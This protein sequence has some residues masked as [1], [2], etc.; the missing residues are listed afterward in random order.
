MEDRRK[1]IHKKYVQQL[2][3]DKNSLPP[4]DE[5]KASVKE[6]RQMKVASKSTANNN[7]NKPVVESKLTQPVI[8]KTQS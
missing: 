5:Y 7:V 8:N 1:F 2:W 3:I 4:L 6:G